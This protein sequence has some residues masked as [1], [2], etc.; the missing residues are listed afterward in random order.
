MESEPQ[1]THGEPAQAADPLDQDPAALRTL[2][3]PAVVGVGERDMPDFF[4]GGGSL[5]HE[6]GADGVVVIPGAGDLAPLEQ[7][8]A[9]CD[10]VVNVMKGE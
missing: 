2:G 5:A 8:A 1:L 4:E 10:L 9:F 6:L 7:P 3:V